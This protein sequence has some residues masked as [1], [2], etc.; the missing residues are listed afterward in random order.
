MGISPDSSLFL[1]YYS[2]P[3]YTKFVY[4]SIGLSLHRHRH[5]K[6]ILALF[7]GCWKHS[8]KKWFLVD[9]HVQPS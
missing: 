3:Q 4:G 2:P 1:Y 9:M 8:Q 6:Y 7:K 5:N